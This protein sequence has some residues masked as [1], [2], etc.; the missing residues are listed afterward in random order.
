MC[1]YQISGALHWQHS[2]LRG[3][4]IYC[5][6]QWDNGNM[7]K[8]IATGDRLLKNKCHAGGPGV[9][10]LTPRFAHRQ[11]CS[12]RCESWWWG[13]GP[14]QHSS[15]CAARSSPSQSR[16]AG[17]GQGPSSHWGNMSQHPLR[18]CV[19][20][21]ITKMIRKTFAYFSWRQHCYW[22]VFCICINIK[23]CVCIRLFCHFTFFAPFILMNGLTSPPPLSVH[24]STGLFFT[25]KKNQTL[26]HQTFELFILNIDEQQLYI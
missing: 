12:N 2:N 9:V 1:H 13:G 25:S 20:T 14:F 22:F 23:M 6:L 24:I 19:Y 4:N 10:L 16:S 15:C 11:V 18:R 7:S 21:H 26:Y 3:Y 17:I 8:N 5:S